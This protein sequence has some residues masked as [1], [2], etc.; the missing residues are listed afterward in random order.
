[1]KIKKGIYQIYGSVKESTRRF[2]IT[3][4]MAILLVVSLIYLNDSIYK[5]TEDNFDKIGRISMVIGLGILLSLS[6]DLLR[7]RYSIKDKLKFLSLHLLGPVI[8]ILYYFLFLKEVNN[9]SLARYTGSI[10]FLIILF[11]YIGKSDK[12][13]YEKYV[14]KIFSNFFLTM[15]YSFVLLVGLFAII[16][17]INSLFDA[18]IDNKYYYYVFLIIYLIFAISF[19]LSK[20]A[21]PD[22]SFDNYDYSP[23]LRILLSY[24]S[25]TLNHLIYYNF[26]FILCQN[27]DQMAV[28]QGFSIP[29]GI[30]VFLYMC[31]NHI[32][33]KS[34]HRGM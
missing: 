20:L 27:I 14:I 23:A 32:F 31:R 28:A 9:V 8:L 10:I 1:M 26:I 25:H 30:M 6:I 21:K 11:F 18:G 5:L 2:P 22:Q 29:S 17:T 24:Y 12:R 34:S 15:I 33:N 13:N 7:E 3:I 16:F 4:S 19:F